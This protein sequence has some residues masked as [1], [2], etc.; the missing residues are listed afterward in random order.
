MLAS[1][2][3]L[4]PDGDVREIFARGGGKPK[5]CTHV[6]DDAALFALV[7]GAQARQGLIDAEL[8][9]YTPAHLTGKIPQVEMGV[10]VRMAVLDIL[11]RRGR[12]ND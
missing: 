7:D 12:R 8:L 6:G 5:K 3:A 10:A 4:E 11:A 1:E 9:D 2:V